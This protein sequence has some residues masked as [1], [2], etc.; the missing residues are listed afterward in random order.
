MVPFYLLSGKG[1]SGPCHAWRVVI[2]NLELKAYSSSLSDTLVGRFS[3][4]CRPVEGVLWGCIWSFNMVN[5]LFTCFGIVFVVA[6]MVVGSH[7]C[8]YCI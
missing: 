5:E 7:S 6:L 3:Y 8:H 2:G 1:C 4:N